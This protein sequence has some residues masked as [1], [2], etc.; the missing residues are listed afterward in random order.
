MGSGVSQTPGKR[1]SPRR[2]SRLEVDFRHAPWSESGIAA[3][4]F[5]GDLGTVGLVADR[6]NGPCL[7]A[8]R[9][10]KQ[11]GGRPRGE[12][13]V[14][15]QLRSCRADDLVGRLT[16]PKEWTRQDEDR[17]GVVTR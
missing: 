15:A 13:I 14:D 9:V 6:G 16:R 8:D 11:L 3:R 10:S 7:V 5:D 2:A 17:R 1:A 12:P 4:Q